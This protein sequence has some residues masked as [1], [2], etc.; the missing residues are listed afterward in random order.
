MGSVANLILI[1][2]YSQTL[3]SSDAPITGLGQ[4]I[5]SNEKTDT[6]T[7]RHI[8]WRKYQNSLETHARSSQFTA[9]PRSLCSKY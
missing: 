9:L 4:F 1:H 3:A 8:S 2:G 5:L 7:V 6:E